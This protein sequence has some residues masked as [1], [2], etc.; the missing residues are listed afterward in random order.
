MH[1]FNRTYQPSP[2]GAPALF[3][4]EVAQFSGDDY[5]MREMSDQLPTINQSINQ[6]IN[7]NAFRSSTTS[8][9]ANGDVRY[10]CSYHRTTPSNRRNERR[11]LHAWWWRMLRS[12]SRMLSPRRTMRLS[13]LR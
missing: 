12:L 5:R 10:K 2:Q 6:S 13:H 11:R 9:S 8:S 7:Q 1:P 4:G 3:D